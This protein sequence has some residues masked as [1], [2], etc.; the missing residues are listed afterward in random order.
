MA[1]IDEISILNKINR[2]YDAGNKTGLDLSYNGN[3][4][5]ERI[6][7][8][9]LMRKYKSFS[10]IYLLNKLPITVYA[11]FKDDDI[12]NN[13]DNI[14]A[15]IHSCISNTDVEV[16]V[17]PVTII[18]P[19]Q[20]LETIAHANL[21]IYR[22]KYNTIEQFEPNGS[23]AL[24]DVG[25]KVESVFKK[26][27]NKFPLLTFVQSGQVCPYTYG[28]QVIEGL[29]DLYHEPE[30]YGGGYCVLWSIFFTELIFKKPTLTSREIL[31]I[32]F[33]KLSKM[34]MIQRG[35]YLRKI[36]HGYV[37]L[38]KHQLNQFFTFIIDNFE[39]ISVKNVYTKRTLRIIH[40]LINLEIEGVYLD[41]NEIITKIKQL[42]KDT[43]DKISYYENMNFFQ[44]WMANIDINVI[45]ANLK[46]DLFVYERYYQY[47]K[48]I[49][50]IQ[51]SKS[52]SRTHAHIG[53]HRKQSKKRYNK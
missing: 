24:L 1:S 25:E 44:R 11:G 27:A 29:S 23:S 9:Y 46:I 33:N 3:E 18:M 51:S 14:H 8:L 31:D 32:F 36:M 52:K 42:K 10:C 28:L 21:L 53:P 5:I 26:I 41:E 4:V 2:T 39:N 17:F 19:V 7:F 49:S 6:F 20:E 13:Y 40:T 30:K 22:K 12:R 16:V 43:R 50:V 48:S 37:V 15:L 34:T 47:Y 35:N 38:L 45:I